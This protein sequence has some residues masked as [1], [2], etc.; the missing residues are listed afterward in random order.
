MYA[1]QQKEQIER[2][3]QTQRQQDEKYSS[4]RKEAVER[5]EKKYES[6]F[7]ALFVV[8][9]VLSR[10]G[11]VVGTMKDIANNEALVAFCDT[12]KSG[13][14]ISQGSVC[15]REEYVSFFKN[16]VRPYTNSS[17]KPFALHHTFRDLSKVVNAALK[18]FSE[19][20][21]RRSTAQVPESQSIAVAQQPS[22]E[23]R[24]DVSE[25]S[26]FHMAQNDPNT[27]EEYVTS[28]KLSAKFRPTSF[29]SF[30]LIRAV[31]PASYYQYQEDIDLSNPALSLAAKKDVDISYTQ[32]E[33]SNYQ[34]VTPEHSSHY[35]SEEP[36]KTPQRRHQ[37]QA[38]QDRSHP[39]KRPQRRSYTVRSPRQYNT[40]RQHNADRQ[41]NHT[42]RT[43]SAAY[44]QRP[45]NYNSHHQ[46]GTYEDTYTYNSDDRRGLNGNIKESVKN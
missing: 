12:V 6:L 38:Y 31:L 27:L 10:E 3:L 33:V 29:F 22:N 2:A 14:H 42:T 19:M 46:P 8:N 28:G 7:D 37:P 23:Y 17:P 41:Y 1:S 9:V 32:N 11:S 44:A 4:I 13:S 35:C 40:D 18:E 26:Q 25:D 20:K 30:T 45:S 39:Q 5:I 16:F 36:S 34:A 15:D 24:L 43:Q 21:E